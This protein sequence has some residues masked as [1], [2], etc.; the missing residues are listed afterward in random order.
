[1]LSKCMRQFDDCFGRIEPAKRFKVCVIGQFSDLQ[2][3]GIEPMAD[4]AAKSATVFLRHL[5]NTTSAKKG[6]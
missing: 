6:I 4:A 3:K 5:R 1:M 2:R